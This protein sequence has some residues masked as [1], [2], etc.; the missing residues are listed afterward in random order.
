MLTVEGTFWAKLADGR[1][2]RAVEV[3]S[4]PP[5]PQHSRI[6][7]SKF[8]SVAC[9]ILRQAPD[10]FRDGQPVSLR[11]WIALTGYHSPEHLR[12]GLRELSEVG[13]VRTVHYDT[14]R[15][16]Y[17]GEPA[18]MWSPVVLSLAAS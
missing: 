6:D 11:Q 5:V 8:S 3:R 15:V 4:L 10:A 13:L 17:A 1:W 9:A 12:S 14:R 16:Q 7:T 2:V 18:L